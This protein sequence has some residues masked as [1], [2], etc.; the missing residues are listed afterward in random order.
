MGVVYRATQL[1]LGRPVAL[2]VIAPQLAD[3][4]D[5]RS[6]F[7]RESQV[8]AS[9]DHPHVIPI[10]HAGESDGT[11]Y[12]A[13]RYVDGTD[14]AEVIEAE[15]RVDGAHAVAI[16][17]EVASALDIAHER[18]L[19][20]RDV[21]PANILVAR[22]GRQEHVYLT[23]FGLMKDTSLVDGLT[24]TGQFVGTVDYAAPEQIEGK[25]S[26]ARA[27][28][29]ALG[30]V[31]FHAVTG[32]RPY[33]RDSDVAKLF[34]HLHDPP[35]AVTDLL[36]AFPSMF[37]DV[38]R[39]ALA[40]N[41]DDRF[42]SAG[43]LAE[44]ASA[45]LVEA[46]PPRPER[47][48]A[49][50]AA[51]PR[52]DRPSTVVS[53]DDATRVRSVVPAGGQPPPEG[54]PPDSDV[55]EPGR[56][57]RFRLLAAAGL[58]VVAV[59]ALAIAL[60]V[61]G[62]DQEEPPRPVPA[63]SAPE[64]EPPPADTREPP[65]AASGWRTTRPAPTPRQ[66]VPAVVHGGAIWLTG[67]LRGDSATASVEGY[68]PI[69]NSWK[70]APELPVKVHHAMAVSYDG[71]LVVLGGWIPEGPD[72][73]ATTSDR[74]FAL[75]DGRT[76]VELPKL[77][78]PRAAGVAAVVGDE[79]VV[80][81]GQA[82]GELVAATEIFDGT[83]WRDGA[84]I[85][86]QRDHLAAAADDRF[87]YAVGGR[88]LSPDQNLDAFERYDVR[89]DSWKKLPPLPTPRG[90]L[91]A[92]L[93]GGRIVA[94]GGEE[95]TRV[96]ENVEAFNLADGAWTALPAMPTPR[97]GLGVAAAGNSLFAVGGATAPGHIST[98]RKSEALRFSDK[99]GQDP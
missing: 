48:V 41:P 57:R 22:N 78:R 61:G 36:P 34:A 88:N 8:A 51:A 93:V 74:V 68:D 58:G 2:K 59:A 67:G 5:F 39:R 77:P 26:T 32:Q 13:M 29:Y 9:L 83:R 20:H 89:A 33:E 94:A 37:D 31:L 27:D 14:L 42:P 81:G 82:D 25:A 96:L 69:I 19:V 72:L 64:A 56:P 97:H 12:I 55:A 44:A 84:P 71:E 10:Y 46:E 3:D 15:G 70:T 85:P 60:V 35:P 92:A 98:S 54:D 11:L 47:S 53:R 91:G 76:W 28:V 66:Q 86:T 21:K 4:P 65:L 99:D 23:D 1:G 6:R 7:E 38:I 40:K 16:V 95:P 17:A 62:G 79:I 87:V 52:F 63:D 45:A 75:R 73:T 18:G 30:C 50:G 49:R 24:Q 80:L 90:G 43:D